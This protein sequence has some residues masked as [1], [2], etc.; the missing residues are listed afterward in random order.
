M[1]VA[2]AALSQ[3]QVK[4]QASER[5]AKANCSCETFPEQLGPCGMGCTRGIAV[6]NLYKVMS[7]GLKCIFNNHQHMTIVFLS[8]ILTIFLLF[9][10][11]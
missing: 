3:S 9:I 5:Q 11:T 7:V 6:V 4:L 10:G 8:Y 2:S 1:T